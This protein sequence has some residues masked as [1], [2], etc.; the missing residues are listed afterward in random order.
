MIP[1]TSKEIADIVGGKLIGDGT[2]LVKSVTTDSRKAEKDALFV[3]LKG[4]RFDGA[5]YLSSLEGRAAAA[6][7]H[8]EEAVS[9]PLIVVEDTLEALTRLSR[10]HAAHIPALSKVVSLTGSVGKTTTKEMIYRVLNTKYNTLRTEGNLNNHIGVPL[11]LMTPASDTEALV[12]EMG[13][14]HK[15]EI[16]HLTG[17]VDSDIAVI[18]NIGHSH[19]ENLGSREGIR[20]AKLEILQ[21]LKKDGV[22]VINGEE[23]LL[24]ID[25]PVR[26]VKVGFDPCFDVWADNIK[27]EEDGVTFTAHTKDE[28]TQIKLSIAGEHNVSNAL[29]AIAVGIITGVSFECIK[30]GLLSYA[31]VGLRQMSYDKNGVTVIADCYNASLESTLASLKTLS[32]TAKGRKIAV[33]GDMLELGDFSGEAHR[34]VGEGVFENRI[35]LLFTCGSL[36]ETTSATADALGVRCAHFHDKESLSCEL[37]KIIEKGDTVLFKASRSMKFERIISLAGLEK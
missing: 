8:R 33:L 7:S 13:M 21:G 31:P 1:L 10:Y 18:T 37:E 9:Y 22:L 30:T 34:R 23:P 17:L 25:Y 4:E 28:S 15:G 16:E 14:N 20:D 32:Q 19:I 24:D 26:T 6:I 11:T 36:S 35:D 3:A 12:V 27:T 2:A 29:L 5:D